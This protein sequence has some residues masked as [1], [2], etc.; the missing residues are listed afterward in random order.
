MYFGSPLSRDEISEI[1][2]AFERAHELGMAT[3]L[4]CYLRNDGFK[5]DGVN[6]ETSTDLVSQANHLGVTI[7]ADII[8]QKMSE[9]NN[10]F[11]NIGF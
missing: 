11:A 10:G 4:W 3:V 9:T 8:K 2:R 7:K 6:Y 5:K 1:A